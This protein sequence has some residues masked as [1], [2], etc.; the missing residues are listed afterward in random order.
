MGFE[1]GVLCV[2]QSLGELLGIPDLCTHR[3]NQRALVFNLLSYDMRRFQLA[4]CCMLWF[5]TSLKGDTSTKGRTHTCALF[6]SS[7]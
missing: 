7:A 3:I 5:G 4:Y 1:I 2:I 6:Y